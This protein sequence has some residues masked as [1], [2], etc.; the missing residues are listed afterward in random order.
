MATAHIIEDLESAL[1]DIGTDKLNKKDYD[2]V[3]KN[4]LSCIDE[5]TRHRGKSLRREIAG[6]IE[7]V[8]RPMQK[9]TIRSMREIAWATAERRRLLKKD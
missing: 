3:L 2:S 8:L 5:V 7:E 4:V 6:L 9:F 1:S